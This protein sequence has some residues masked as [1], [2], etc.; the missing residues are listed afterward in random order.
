MQNS[1]ISLPVSTLWVDWLHSLQLNGPEAAQKKDRAQLTST[2][3]ETIQAF[4]KSHQS[5]CGG[6]AEGRAAALALEQYS[7]SVQ[8]SSELLRGVTGLKGCDVEGQGPNWCIAFLEWLLSEGCGGVRR[9]PSGDKISSPLI[10][11]RGPNGHA[12]KLSA[13]EVNTDLRKG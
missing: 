12:V 1:C 10:C 9:G 7:A 13:K 6:A 5:S 2:T 3:M 11:A 8:V 4:L